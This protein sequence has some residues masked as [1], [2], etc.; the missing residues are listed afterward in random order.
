MQV[1]MPVGE[2]DNVPTAVSLLARQG[3]DRFLLD[4]VLALY[5]SIQEE[6]QA[7][8]DH[9]STVSNGTTIAAELAKEKVWV[10]NCHW[11]LVHCVLGVFFAVSGGRSVLKTFERTILL[12]FQ[13][14]I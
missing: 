2:H 7:D 6:D 1:T 9:H 5:S 14:I 13:V 12:L 8:A 11:Y 3:S 10:S 4:T